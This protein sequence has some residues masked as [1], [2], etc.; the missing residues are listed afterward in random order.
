VSR[1]DRRHPR[2][3]KS[4]SGG[5][6]RSRRRDATRAPAVPSGLDGIFGVHAVSALLKSGETPRE[7]WVQEGRAETRLATLVEQAREAG[8]RLVS[9]PRDTLD[10]LAGGSV[11][12]GVIAFCQPLTPQ[13]EEALWLRLK[14]WPQAWPHSAPPLLL[15]LDGVTDVHNLGACLRSADATGVHGV[16]MAKDNTAPLNATVRKVA[17][18]AAESVPVYQVTN[19]V[20]TMARLKEAGL[21]LT[22]TAGE[23]EVSLFEADLV[24]PSALVM[25]AEGKGLRRLTRQA[26]D[27]LIKLP[28]T[29][30]VES[31]NV[32]VAT[33]V[34][35]FEALRQRHVAAG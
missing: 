4:A 10:A 3:D 18:G 16:I 7:L 24:G 8:T 11:H 22:G 30:T 1:D 25:G 33:G 15:V 27:H 23:A 6:S 5:P 35:L 13:N 21:W 29:G 20:R 2:R 19:L 12:Q 34:C 26:C 9:Q 17:S 31:L 32:S 28:M 14:G